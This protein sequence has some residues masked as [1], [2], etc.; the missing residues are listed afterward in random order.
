MWTPNGRNDRIELDGDVI[1]YRST[2]GTIFEL[3]I[4]D[5]SIIAESMNENG[6]F[7]DDWFYCFV[8]G[9][10]GWTEAPVYADGGEE[11]LRRLSERLKTPIE[12][13]FASVTD[14]ASRIVWPLELRG[15][16]LFEFHPVRSQIWFHQVLRIPEMQQRLTAEVI[17][18]LSSTA[19]R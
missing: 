18:Y 6:P 17:S 7:G 2:T 4:S 8:T 19:E 14:F 1:R 13:E 15:R 9:S 16:P 12:L 5:I 11:F 3:A 10:R